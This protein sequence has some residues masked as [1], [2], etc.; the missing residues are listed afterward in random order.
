[1]GAA[2]AGRMLG[3]L[4]GPIAEAKM[5]AKVDAFNGAQLDARLADDVDIRFGVKVA[6]KVEINLG[7]D[8]ILACLIAVLALLGTVIVLALTDNMPQ[9]SYW[10]PVLLG[11]AGLV[12]F[13]N[14]QRQA[15]IKN[16]GGV[17]GSRV[18]ELKEP[19]PPPS[20]LKEPA[21][22][23]QAQLLT[24][25]EIEMSDFKKLQEAVEA[26]TEKDPKHDE[27]MAK[28]NKLTEAKVPPT[29]DAKG[30]NSTLLP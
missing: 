7:G 10:L 5:E 8:Y 1:M 20:Q 16:S 9:V 6:P 11:I 24:A 21:P 23:Q 26:A 29:N 15:S 18:P 13:Y 27:I 3:P 25:G 30:V 2:L 4:M 19:P 12:Y 14:Q 17:G 28:L 22:R